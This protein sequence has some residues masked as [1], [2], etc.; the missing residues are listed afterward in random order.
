MPYT[1]FASLSLIF[2][3]SV[4]LALLWSKQ[5]GV[6][7]ACLSASCRVIWVFPILLALFP[8]TTTEELPRSISSQQ[9]HILI[10]DSDSMQK[11]SG[12]QSPFSKAMDHVKSIEQECV[13]LGCQMPTSFRCTLGHGRHRPAVPSC[14]HGKTRLS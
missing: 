14:S 12:L 11:W 2:F 9:I 6:L 8:Q 5:L 13:R 7:R 1:F 4:I 10:D 3:L